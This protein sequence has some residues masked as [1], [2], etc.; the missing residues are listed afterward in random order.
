MSESVV[1]SKGT[2]VV[3]V[4]ISGQGEVNTGQNVGTGAGVFKEKVGADFRYRTVVGGTGITAT[5]NTDDVTLD[6]PQEVATDSAV[7]FTSVNIAGQTTL[8]WNNTDKTLDMPVNAVT[9][10]L[11]QE[12]VSLVRNNTGSVIPDGS[13]VYITGSSGNKKTIALAANTDE[14]STESVFGV[15]TEEIANNDDGFITIIGLV[16]GLDTSALTEGAPVY[17]GAVAGSFTDVKPLTPAHLVLVGYV[18]NSHVTQGSVFVKVQNGYEIEELHNVLITTPTN[19]QSLVWDNSNEYWINA[20]L[21]IS[22]FTDT[23]G[24]LTADDLSNNDTDDL[25]EGTTNLYYTDARVSSHL[26]TMDGSI[27]PDTDIAY[28]LGS[29]SKQWRDVYIGPGSLYVNGKKVIED[30]SGTIT[31]ETDPNQNLRIKTTGTGV[32]QINSEQTI[33]LTATNSAD[34]ELTTGTGQIELNGDVVIDVT[35]ALSTSTGGTL[36]V[37]APLDLGTN[38]LD[39]NNLT[40]DGNLTV[41]GTTTTVNTETINLADNTILLNSNFVGVTPS[42]N[43]GIEI[44]RGGTAPNKTFIWDETSDRWTLGS[45]TLVA[46]SVIADVTGDVTGTVTD[47]SNHTTS[48]L[49]EGTNLYYTDSRA[50]ARIALQTG[51]N[52]DLSSKTTTDLDEGTNLYYTDTRVQSVIN[53]NTAGYITTYDPTEADIT[54]H[55]AALSITESQISDL[56]HYTNADFDTQ[57]ATKSTADVTE[58][59]NLYYTDTRANT[60]I[61]ARVTKSFVENLDIDVDGGSY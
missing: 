48:D 61:D 54:Q 28:D 18:V 23:G 21:D 51:A 22:D 15:A 35:K 7:Q 56:D 14:I 38:D 36:T 16:R 25:S 42:E 46:G 12:T 57:L 31:V 55:Q 49:D 43:S 17:L 9:I 59:A 24:L 32:T 60:A 41:S 20:Q 50:D 5:Q 45:E 27:I 52:L 10:Q 44:N 39:V 33:Q 19:N 13:V 58:G 40:V 53:T 1:I 8:S 26:L 34:I 3:N 29:A 11:G 4:S 6:L 2:D 37:N 47:I 30:D